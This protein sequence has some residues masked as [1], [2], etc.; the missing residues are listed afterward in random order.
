MTT[1]WR[2]GVVAALCAALMCT[3]PVAATTAWA[4]Q[5][6]TGDTAATEQSVETRTFVDSF[7]R[8][9]EIPVNVERIAASGSIAQQVLMTI[10]PEKMV[11]VSSS[12]SDDELK[13]FGEEWK[14]LPEFGSIVGG[15]GDFNKEAVALADPQVVIDVGQPKDGLAEDLDALQ[16]QIGIPCVFIETTIDSFD[17]SYEMLGE[18]LGVPERAEELASYCK[19]AYETTTEFME[20][21]PE[22]ELVRVAYLQGDAGLNAMP[23][24]SY[25]GVIVDMCSDNVVVIPDVVASGMGSEISLEQLAIWNPD[26]IIFGA[27][28]IYD[29][30]ADD[31]AWQVINAI[32]DGNYYQIPNQPYDWMNR[33]PSVNQLLG[34]QWFVRLCYPDGF[35][36]DIQDVVKSYYKTFYGYELTDE[37]C[38][39]LLAKAWPQDEDAEK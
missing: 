10:A 23:Q 11:G 26:L 6:K 5:G 7:G 18:L 35:E 17:Q 21:V 29:T 4:D 27:N 8:E 25:H 14:D 31:P 12:L 37:E 2:R 22:D 19:E 33:P 39:E 16:E 24:G 13:Y 34:I 3:A 15:K 36:D 38:D 32:A 9:V 28:S 1:T 30:V 20:T